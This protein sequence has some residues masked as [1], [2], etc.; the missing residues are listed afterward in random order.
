MVD[1]LSKYGDI[2][3]RGLVFGFAGAS[4]AASRSGL[5]VVRRAI[6]AVNS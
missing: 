6:V 1:S 3:R 2:A 5:H 4:R